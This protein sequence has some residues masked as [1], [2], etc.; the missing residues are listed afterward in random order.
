MPKARREPRPNVGVSREL[1]LQPEATQAYDPASQSIDPKA[2]VRG[3]R[4]RIQL[5]REYVEPDRTELRNF[6]RDFHPDTPQGV[7][8]ASVARL[9]QPFEGTF[10][11]L[12]GADRT[13]P[14]FIDVS[15]PNRLRGDRLSC[16]PQKYFFFPP[17]KR[18]TNQLYAEAL[19]RQGKLLPEHAAMVA[20]LAGATDPGR[21][22]AD[23]AANT[24]V[25][26]PRPPPAPPGAGAG[27]AGSGRKTRKTRKG[28]KSRKRTMRK[29]Y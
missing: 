5:R 21:V 23:A 15:G 18:D 26:L 20:A 19:A 11:E 12:T 7:I 1:G 29:Y 17:G 24:G 25:S 14:L 28:R 10:E 2:L 8:N 16:P 13:I 27:P 3:Q 6:F 4:Y 9:A 22:Y